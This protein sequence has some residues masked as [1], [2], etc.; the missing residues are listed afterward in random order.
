MVY[1]DRTSHVLVN[2]VDLFSTILETFG[3]DSWKSSVPA[4]R[5]IDSK[6]LMP[7]LK[8]NSDSIR[9]WTF[10][11]I[12][13]LTTDDNDGKTIRNRHYQL[14]KFDYGKQ[15]LFNLTKDPLEK[16]DLLTEKLSDTDVANYYFLCNELAKLLG[17]NSFCQTLVKDTNLPPSQKFQAYPNPFTQFITFEKI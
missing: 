15:K 13:K 7:F 14:M 1:P 8:N 16:I 6:S 12:F 2:T 10:S 17:V 11:E 3:F 9:N 5:P 4:S